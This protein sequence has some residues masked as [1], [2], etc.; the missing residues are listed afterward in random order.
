MGILIRSCFLRKLLLMM[1]L[2]CGW[3]AFACSQIRDT[4]EIQGVKFLFAETT[5]EVDGVESQ[6]INLVRLGQNGAKW[7]L[8]HTLHAES[9]D[10]NSFEVE[11]GGYTVTD[12]NI[13]FYTAWMY[14]NNAM[15]GVCG[16]RKQVFRVQAN[17]KVDPG[18]SLFWVSVGPQHPCLQGIESTQ[19][20][21]FKPLP[22]RQEHE[23]L[24]LFLQC[25]ETEFQGDILLGVAMDSLIQEVTHAL[26]KP[27]ARVLKKYDGLMEFVKCF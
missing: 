1:A 8:K 18:P 4:V 14:T 17:G 24:L 3:P 21:I 27:M 20:A 15:A 16:V 7:L 13:V 5:D 6:V 23:D 26:R 9:P 2:G 22:S 19:E 12:T 25:V 10:C 11:L